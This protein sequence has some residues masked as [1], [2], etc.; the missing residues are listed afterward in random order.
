MILG[1]LRDLGFRGIRGN[2][3]E[4]RVWGL[5]FLGV[6]GIGFRV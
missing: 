4:F 3:L 6:Q 5:G 2:V 1:D